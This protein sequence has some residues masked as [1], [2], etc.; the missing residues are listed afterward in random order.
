MKK[1][2]A[3]NYSVNYL[4]KAVI[5]VEVSALSVEEALEKAKIRMNKSVFTAGLEVCDES[6]S[7]IGYGLQDG[8]DEI[9]P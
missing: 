1:E 3:R 4:V 2:S 8:W 9:R 5:S 7:M 6:D